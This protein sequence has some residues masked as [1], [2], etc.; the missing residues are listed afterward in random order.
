MSKPG[1]SVSE[2]THSPVLRKR[3]RNGAQ[4][5]LAIVPVAHMVV[6]PSGFLVH[7][8][9]A[10]NISQFVDSER[11]EIGTFWTHHTI[12]HTVNKVSPSIHIAV[13]RA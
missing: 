4:Q 2:G 3:H 1:P 5:I 10:G 7:R 9:V 12:R 6:R 13:T 11:T 8:I